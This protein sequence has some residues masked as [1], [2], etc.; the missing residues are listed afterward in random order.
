MRLTKMV[1]MFVSLESLMDMEVGCPRCLIPPHHSTSAGNIVGKEVAKFCQVYFLRELTQ[2][3]YFR[4][5]QFDLALKRCFHRMD[6]MIEDP[7]RIFSLSLSLSPSE[8]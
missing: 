6:E 4:D 8:L 5:R 2:I 1:I 3:E 7:V